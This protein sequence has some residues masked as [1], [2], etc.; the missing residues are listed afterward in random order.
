MNYTLILLITFINLSNSL[1]FLNKNNW[2]ILRNYI[3][4]PETTES[5]REKVK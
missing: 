3:K 5:M 1:K 2:I 4:S